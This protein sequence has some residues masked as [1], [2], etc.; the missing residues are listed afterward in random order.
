M[1]VER[2]ECRRAEDRRQAE[3]IERCIQGYGATVDWFNKSFRTRDGTEGTWDL[4]QLCVLREKKRRDKDFQGA[5]DMRQQLAAAGC[6][7]DDK[8]K[9]YT[10]PD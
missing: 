1:C 4:A 5:D 9:V 6:Q 3:D 10:L 8:T 7:C 2:E